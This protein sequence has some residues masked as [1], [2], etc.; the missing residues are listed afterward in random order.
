VSLDRRTDVATIAQ[1]VNT[2]GSWNGTTTFDA[3]PGVTEIAL[4]AAAEVDQHSGYKLIKKITNSGPGPN[5]FGATTY[6][7]LGLNPGVRKFF[8][9]AVPVRSGVVDLDI[10]AAGNPAFA[11]TANAIPGYSLAQLQGM[12]MQP[13]VIVGLDPT[14]GLYHPLNVVA[15]SGGGMKLEV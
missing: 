1:T 11:V 13:I 9:R 3:T 15:G 4:F 5:S 2:L 12:G 14:T 8:L 6:V 10:T 7:A